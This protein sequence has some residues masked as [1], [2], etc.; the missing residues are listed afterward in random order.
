MDL[1]WDLRTFEGG[2]AGPSPPPAT[3]ESRLR[4]LEQRIDR[5][6]MICC[7]MWTVIQSTADISDEKLA[8]L[9]QEIDLADGT[10]DGKADIE[11]VR[12]CPQCHR[13]VHARHHRCIYC[14]AEASSSSPFDGV[15]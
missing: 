10:L 1:F 12:P 7:A 2:R 15:L 9:V 3:S 11:Q 4:A 13:P 8:Q 6:S 5:L 14:G